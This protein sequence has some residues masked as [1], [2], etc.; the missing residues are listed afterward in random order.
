MEQVYL[1]FRVGIAFYKEGKVFEGEFF[2]NE[3]SGF[4]TEIYANGNLYV[5]QFSQNK[6]HGEGTFYWFSLS[7]ANKEKLEQYHG[8]WWGGLPD[9]H[10]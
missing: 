10:G 2:L 5:G 9:G 1:C 8:A 4:G 3:K 7:D 6:K